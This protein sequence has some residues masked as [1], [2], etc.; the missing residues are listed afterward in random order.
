MGS[1]KRVRSLVLMVNL[2]SV[3]SIQ[4]NVIASIL[5]SCLE[6]V[7]IVL[8]LVVEQNK[9]GSQ[10]S[11]IT[12]K[13]LVSGMVQGV[14]FRYHT[15]ALAMRL[16]LKGRATNLADGR[17]EVVVEGEEDVV[18]NMLDWLKT[19]PSSARVEHLDCHPCPEEQGTFTDFRA[20]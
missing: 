15:G 9:G 5:K 14:G 1:Q 18:G 11:E 13:V 7:S 12:L 16:G 8:S 2:A 10:L 19:G 4:R 20:Y 6:T 17:V 3:W